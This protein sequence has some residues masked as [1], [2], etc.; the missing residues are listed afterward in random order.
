M[1]SLLGA[2][3]IESRAWREGVRS[4]ESGG[5]DGPE[6]AKQPGRSLSDQTGH[7]FPDLAE[8]YTGGGYDLHNIVAWRGSIDT[9]AFHPVAEFL[10]KADGSWQVL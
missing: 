8:R 10:K 7:A 9:P 5:G 1:A 6:I 2:D 3:G 4:Q